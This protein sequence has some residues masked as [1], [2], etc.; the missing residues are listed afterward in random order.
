MALLLACFVGV[1][2]ARAAEVQVISSVD[3]EAPPPES[4]VAVKAHPRTGRPYASIV[5]PGEAP[6]AASPV[7]PLERPDYRYLHAGRGEVA[8]Q[9]PSSDR[10]KVYVLAGT[11]ATAGV[12]AGMAGLA[13]A[14]AVAGA[15]AAGSPVVPAAAA[16]AL[17]ALE[18]DYVIKTLRETPED[19]QFERDSSS[20]VIDYGP[21]FRPKSDEL[22]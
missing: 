5:A 14:P 16:A 22:G 17:L 4:G 20:R 6:E 13:T 3:L 21:G 9:G 15:A 12:A 7:R 8:Y 2:P 1:A 10:T 18:G 11:L 19:R